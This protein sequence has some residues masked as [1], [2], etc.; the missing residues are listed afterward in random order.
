MSEGQVTIEG[1]RR[2]LPRPFFVVA[3]QNPSDYAGT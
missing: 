3:T 2:E 1:D